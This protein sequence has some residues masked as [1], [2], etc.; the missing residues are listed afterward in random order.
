MGNSHLGFTLQAPLNHPGVCLCDL[1][2]GQVQYICVKLGVTSGSSSATAGG[3]FP[4][5]EA[6]MVYDE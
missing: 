5:F 4:D 1:M 3:F 2:F 6:H